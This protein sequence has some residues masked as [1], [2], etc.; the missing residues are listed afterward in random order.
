MKSRLILLSLVL[1][2]IFLFPFNTMAATRTISNVNIKCNH[3]IQ[4]GDDIR[5]IDVNYGSLEGAGINVVTSSNKYY[6]E[7]AEVYSTSNRRID[8]GDEIKLKVVLQP[9]WNDSVDYEFKGTYS[10]SNVNISGGEFVSASKRDGNL[11]VVLRLKGVK[12][13]YNPPED[14]EW[15][16]SDNNRRIG[17]GSWE[18]RDFSSG[19]YDIMLYRNN[20]NILKVEDY[21]GKSFNF[22]PYMTQKG[23]YRFKVRTVAH[24]NNEKSY[25]KSS[26]WAESDEYYLDE[27]RVSDGSG[28]QDN[29]GSTNNSPSQVGW[30]K[31]RDIWYYRYPDGSY[32]KSG[33]EKV[34]DKW[35]LFDSSG[36]MVT[37]WQSINNN[38]Y[39]LNPSGD[40]KT[41]W[42]KD[43]NKWYF[44]NS[45]VGSTSEGALMKNTWLQT[46]DGKYYY[47]GSN[48][49][50]SEGWNKI[51]NLWY[52]FYPESGYMARDTII[53]TFYVG[54]DGAWKK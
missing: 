6:I 3:N 42:I 9:A 5:D 38:T 7:Y 18:D 19:Y 40:M 17:Y 52:Y 14:V 34:A 54:K 13:Q 24:T 26:D 12:G 20:S 48:G 23:T 32:K 45:T 2:T 44:L 15:K 8:V 36:R 10:A 28:R 47:M 22:Y 4:I 39:Y 37:G 31:D 41:G 50:M 25:A 21:K 53:D 43:G 1:S 27:S 46:P 51:N 33:W 30:I 16:D 11:A 35:Y 49:A 29:I